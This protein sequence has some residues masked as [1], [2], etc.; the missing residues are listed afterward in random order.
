M[1]IP[2][3]RQQAQDE[4]TSPE[5]LTKLARSKN[6]QT[7]KYVAE[8]PNTPIEIETLDILCQ[9]FPDKI[10]ANPIF[11]LLLLENPDSDFIRLSLARSSTTNPETLARLA[12]L[13]DMNIADALACNV[14]TP[15]HILEKLSNLLSCPVG[16]AANP[17]TPLSVLEKLAVHKYLAVR[18]AVARNKNVSIE[19]SKKLACDRD[20][21]VHLAIAQNINAPTPI[22]EI[23]A[24]RKESMVRDA[25]LKHPNLADSVLDIIRFFDERGRVDPLILEKLAKHPDLEVRQIVADHISTPTI[26]LEQLAREDDSKILEYITIH[27]NASIN[28]LKELALRLIE[29]GRQNKRI[30]TRSKFFLDKYVLSRCYINLIENSHIQLERKLQLVD[31]IRSINYTG[32]LLK[33]A[34]SNLVESKILFMLVNDQAI[35]SNILKNYGYT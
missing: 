33:I 8:N 17:N 3:E 26:V 32:V 7:R 11:N 28:I 9:E 6:Y 2:E 25:I 34:Q 14:S 30:E 18:Q 16:V 12:E 35:Y 13:D 19:I 15:L 22:L 1:N 10:T 31:L 21:R 29:H 23:L 20:I 24:A 27:P 5:V 4:N